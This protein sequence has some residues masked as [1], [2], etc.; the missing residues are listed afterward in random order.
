MARLHLGLQFANF[1]SKK[2]G[3]EELNLLARTQPEASKYCEI[4]SIDEAV[5]KWT[6]ESGLIHHKTI[7]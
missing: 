5:A 7:L 2:D 1:S 6:F 3:E 4:I